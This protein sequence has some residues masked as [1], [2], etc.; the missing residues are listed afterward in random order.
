VAA[1]VVDT[2]LLLLLIV[3]SAD[4]N[5]IKIHKN[6]SPAYTEAD[7]DLLGQV[8]S[9]YSDIVLLPHVMAEV[10]SLA[11]QIKNPARAAIQLKLAELV[12][13]AGEVCVPSVA[14]VHR[15]EFDRLGLT[16]SVILHLCSLNQNGATFALLTADNG[17]AVQA[18]ML[19]YEVLN[20]AHLQ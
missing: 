5:F 13:S 2:N 19:E 9:L 14:G 16:D 10:S 4:K 12:E 11:R 18:E 17:L 15:V 8:I 7:F 20:F 1:V 6:L 3:G